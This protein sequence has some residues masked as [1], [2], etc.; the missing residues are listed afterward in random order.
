MF[1]LLAYIYSFFD[2]IA[3]KKNCSE[4]TKALVIN[5]VVMSVSVREIKLLAYFVR[6]PSHSR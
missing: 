1:L 4:G 5:I 2:C 6:L 3:F